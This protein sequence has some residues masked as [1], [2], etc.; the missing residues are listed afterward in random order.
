MSDATTQLV[1]AAPVWIPIATVAAEVLIV[2]FFLHYM[3]KR[4]R[5]QQAAGV[6]W[7]A[8]A[9]AIS[10]RCHET[11]DA[12][13]AAVREIAVQMRELST[14]IMRLNGKVPKGP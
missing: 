8:E 1:G 10:D 4:D 7:A 5:A 12:A 14:H 9:K 6:A 13:T 2:S 3:V 11:Q